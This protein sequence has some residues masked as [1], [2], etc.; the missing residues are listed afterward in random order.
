M[1]EI[2]QAALKKWP[3]VPH[4]YGWLALDARGD[5]YM[6]DERIQHAGPFP[7]VKGSRIEHDKLRA[8]IERNYAADAAG[9]WYFQNGPQRVYVELEATPWIWRLQPDG[10]V[11]SHTG[12][13]ATVQSSCLDE[14][15]R[16]YLLTD[17]GPGL[18]HTADMSLAADAVEQGLWSPQEARS[19]ELPV[20]F[21]FVRRPLP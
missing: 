17:L 11:L 19:S 8:F 9:C 12:V 3:N 7:Q 21:A 16:L 14:E 15:G 13:Q 4:C 6:R 2:V 1:D 18:V 10:R 5:W 20:R